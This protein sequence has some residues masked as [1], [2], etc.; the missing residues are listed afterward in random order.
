MKINLAYVRRLEDLILQLAELENARAEG[1]LARRMPL[2]HKE[3]DA[4]RASRR[5]RGTVKRGQT[6]KSNSCSHE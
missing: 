3:A 2:L 4:I 6:N 1:N 5:A